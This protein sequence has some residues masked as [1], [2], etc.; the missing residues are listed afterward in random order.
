MK[1]LT[2][3]IFLCVLI[4]YAGYKPVFAGS[5]EQQWAAGGVDICTVVGDRLDGYGGEMAMVTDGSEGAIIVWEDYRNGSVTDWDIYAQRVD[6]DGNIKWTTNGV[7]ICTAKNMQRSPL[8]V[9]D[10][11]GGAII[12]WYDE[13]DY[14]TRC[15]DI[16]AQQIDANGNIQWGTSGRPVCIQ[17]EH[18][19]NHLI[20]SDGSGGAIVVWRDKR[21]FIDLFIPGVYGQRINASGAA[22]WGTDGR[23]ITSEVDGSASIDSLVADGSG[24]AYVVL[25]DYRNDNWDVYAQRVDANGSALW[26]SDK[27]VC[28]V[29]DTQQYSSA[30]SLGGNGVIVVWDDDRDN[31]YGQRVDAS[32]LIKWDTDGVRVSNTVS[33]NSTDKTAIVT[34]GSGGAIVGWLSVTSGYY[35]I[36][37]HRLDADG[38]LQWSSGVTIAP[39][40]AHYTL[41][42]LDMVSD[43]SGGAFITWY[44]FRSYIDYDVYAQRID[45]SG[46]IRWDSGGSAV[47]TMPG[48]QSAPAMVLSGDDSIIVAWWDYS[49]TQTDYAIK[50]QKLTGSQSSDTTT[51]TTGSGGCFSE[52]LYGEYSKEAEL[53][54]YFRDDV[55][56][57]TP[58]GQEIIRLYYQLSPVIVK[59]MEKDKQFKEEMKEMIDGILPLIF[60]GEE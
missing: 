28:T 25:A 18:Q 48:N 37:I 46:N 57:K 9:S 36:D 44:D 13:R 35:G 53:L 17:N 41:E 52:L 10:G 4:T 43:G 39:Q 58:E 33:Y 19:Y 59:A 47:C 3:I 30:V 23:L 26:S 40:I 8:V 1:D 54:R 34:D 11:I 14:S 56:G 38:V 50:A 42:N 12:A 6:T 2:K 27:P 55:L 32:G 22:L 29:S 16:Y 49:L 24:G 20:V 15:G 45:A 60:E 31:I 5:G 7:A 21:D 51:T